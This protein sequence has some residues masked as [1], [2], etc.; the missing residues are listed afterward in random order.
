MK[1]ILVLLL[2]VAAEKKWVIPS[3]EIS[4]HADGRFAHPKSSSDIFQFLGRKSYSLHLLQGQFVHPLSFSIRACSF[5]PH[6]CK[7]PSAGIKPQMAGIYT[8]WIIS[9]W[10]VM[11]H[12]QTF[13]NW[14][15]AQYPSSAMCVNFLFPDS[16]LSMSGRIFISSPNPA[17]DETGSFIN[18]RPESVGERVGKSLQYQ[19]LRGNFNHSIQFCRFGLQARPA[20]SL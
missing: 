2:M 19:V 4:D 3:F 9:A 16:D 5:G 13:R 20:F 11:T 12:V 1:I 18:S 14:P 7:I 8:G 10:T 15:T 6:V 17:S